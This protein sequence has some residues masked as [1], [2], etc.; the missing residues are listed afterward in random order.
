MAAYVIRH[1][2]AG[3]RE[4]WEG[5]DRLRPLTKSGRRQAD[6]LV[7]ILM[8][9]PIDKI[10]SS[11]YVR[12]VQSVEPLARARNL[13][14]ETTSDLEEGA[15]GESIIRLIKQYSS[16]NIALCTHGDLLEEL[17]ERLLDQGVISRRRASNEKGGTWVL[18]DENGRVTQ[19]T[20]LAAP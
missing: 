9:R 11:P 12:C 7:D 5:D 15:G 17:L 6:A 2:R 13:P 10:L 4:E 19:A 16:Q 1:A 20:Y 14:V 8:D 18:E 3:D